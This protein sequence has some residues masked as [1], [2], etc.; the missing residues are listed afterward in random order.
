MGLWKS[1]DADLYNEALDV[2]DALLADLEEMEELKIP[3][4]EE[5]ERELYERELLLWVMKNAPENWREELRKLYTAAK[6]NV[7][8]RERYP[9]GLQGPQP[10]QAV[11]EHAEEVLQRAKVE[12]LLSGLRNHR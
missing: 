3:L 2:L 11:V 1:M 4:P 5:V 8:K 10:T 12:T 6:S 9:S 7:H